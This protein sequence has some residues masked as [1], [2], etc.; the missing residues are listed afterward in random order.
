MGSCCSLAGEHMGTEPLRKGFFF[1]FFFVAV[2]LFVK[3]AGVDD[4][5][6]CSVVPLHVTSVAFAKVIEAGDN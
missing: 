1:F 6:S 3:A 2:I 4:D 5:L